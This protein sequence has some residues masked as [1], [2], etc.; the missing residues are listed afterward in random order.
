MT[1]S[2]VRHEKR[3]RWAVVAAVAAVL[4]SVPSVVAALA[5]A[6]EP[7]DPARL[8]A[9]VLGSAGRPYQGYAESSGSL[10]LPE[11]PNLAAVTA[12]FSGRTPMRAWYAAPDRYRVDILGT[13]GEHDVY[14]LPDGEY[15]WDYGDNTLTEAD[16]GA[17]RPA[18]ARRGPAAAR[19]GAADPPG[20]EGR[21]GERAARAERRRRRRVRAAAR[22]RRSGHDDRAGG[23]LGGPGTGLPVRVEVTA[24]GQQAPILVTEFQQLEQTTP[25]VEAPRP[26]LGSGFTVASAPDVSNTLGAFGQVPLP[27]SLRRAPG[28][29]VELRRG[30]GRRALRRRAGVV[31]GGRRAAERRR[32]RRATPPGRPARYAGQAA[33]RARVVQLSIT[34]LS[35]A[36]VRSTA[37][38][39]SYLLA[40]T[41]TAGRAEVGRGRA[42]P[43]APERPMIVTRALTKRYGATV[44]VDAVDLEVREGDRYGFLGPNGSGKTTLVR[45]LLGLVYATSGEIE[46]LG[47]PVPKRV[48]EVLPQVGALV[49][50]PA[51]YPHLSGRRN[52]TLLDAAGR[53]GA[54][55]TRRKRIEDVLEQVGLGGVDQRPV[56]AYSLGMRQRLGL[57]GALL[58]HPRLLILDEPTNGL[59][60][61]GI[62]EIRELL[63]EL[64]AGGTTVFLS[65]HLLAEVEQLCTRVG[66]VDRGRLVLEEDLGDAAG[67]DRPGPG[68]HAGPGRGGRGPRRAARVPR[69]RPPG[70]PARRP[71]GAER[72]ARRSRGARDVDPRRA[73]DPRTGRPRRDGS[74]LG[75]VRGGRMIGVELRKL[76]LRPR[77]WFSVLL[78][79]PAARDRRRL[80]GDGR[81][82]AAARAGRGVPVGGGE[83]RRAVPG[84]RARPGAAVVPADRGRGHRGRLDRG[85]GVHRDPAL[86]A[87]APGRPDP[88]AGREDGG[89]GRV[90]DRGDRHRRAD[91]AGARRDPVRHRRDARVSPGR[92]GS[93]PG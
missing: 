21:P 36:I 82:R 24:R 33:R 43:A 65:S 60:P 86:P 66:V 92:A 70:H 18:P 73:A 69:R 55:R 17:D 62:K 7:A 1:P 28:G 50:G 58:R 30:R 29:V 9:L 38:R 37:S 8:R 10:A 51:A 39:R 81:L 59:D 77:V 42:V 54:R 57:A 89:A 6:G 19:A 25:V 5:P 76:V 44:A 47:R 67:G 48:A 68:R 40:G 84:R 71:G 75:P 2:V 11:L 72:A 90:R 61:Q 56:K 74:G 13:A 3:R 53:G 34:P 27:A 64:N 22:P 88:A 4:V 79:L 14:R 52:L 46:V 41:V 49:E 26:V 35:L 87:G 83:R 78:L 20:G 12:L 31:R 23:R 15:T 45:M 91:V 16:R 93:R 80:P 32:S 85:R 63:V